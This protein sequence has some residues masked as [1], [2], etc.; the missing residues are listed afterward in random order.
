[1]RSI[2]ALVFLFSSSLATP[3]GYIEIETDRKPAEVYLDG[4][5]IILEDG[6]AIVEAAPG[7]HFVSLFPPRKVYQAFR[8]ET[9]EQFW[10]ALRGEG[11]VSEGRRLLSSYERGAVREGTRWVY[12]V[13]DDTIPVRLSATRTDDVYRRDSSCLLG[14]FLGWTLLIGG[15]MALSVI[16]ARLQ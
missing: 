9:P 3:A 10:N 15:G 5:L 13:A 2:L 6:P 12:A 11:A 4:R 14:T 16:L 7:R 8:D 1:M